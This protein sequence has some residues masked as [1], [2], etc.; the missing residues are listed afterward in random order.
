MV[1]DGVASA[2]RHRQVRLRDVGA[3]ALAFHLHRLGDERLPFID[4]AEA[5]AV[6]RLEAPSHL[7]TSRER[8]RKRHVG[9][10]VADMDA[11]CDHDIGVVEALLVKLR[12]NFGFKRCTHL[13]QL[14]FR[15]N[16]ER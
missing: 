10:V 14:R 3:A 1:F 12:A 8:H 9:A 6:L 15:F 2:S 4:E 7:V 11:R 16:N 13:F 5:L